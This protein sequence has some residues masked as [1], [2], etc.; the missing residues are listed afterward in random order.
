MSK[1]HA[2]A[3]VLFLYLGPLVAMENEN[4][5]NDALEAIASLFIQPASKESDIVLHQLQKLN[6]RWTQ[7]A[8]DILKIEKLLN[9]PNITMDRRI[10]CLMVQ[11]PLVEQLTRLE[12]QK[13]AIINRAQQYLD[14]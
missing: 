11:V 8:T 9:D 7:V 1:L 3:M 13:P 6:E 2:L 4:D 14:K 5:D 10:T 12:E